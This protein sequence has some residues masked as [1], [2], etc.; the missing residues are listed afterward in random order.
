[1]YIIYHLSILSRSTL[2]D[3]HRHLVAMT[4]TVTVNLKIIIKCRRM[5]LI[6]AFLLFLL[7]ICKNAS[8]LLCKRISLSMSPYNATSFRTEN[9]VCSRLVQVQRSRDEELGLYIGRSSVST[10]WKGSYSSFNCTCRTRRLKTAQHTPSKGS[11]W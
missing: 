4:D 10:T 6:L 9:C 5:R 7:I 1:M 11:L 8:S 3:V 2:Y